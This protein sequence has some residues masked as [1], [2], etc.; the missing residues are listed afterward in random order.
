M[1]T[2][3]AWSHTV[4]H[5]QEHHEN[6]LMA[7][8][9]PDLAEEIGDAARAI[10]RKGRGLAA[11]RTS[12]AGGTVTADEGTRRTTARLEESTSDWFGNAED[13]LARLGGR[14]APKPSPPK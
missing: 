8:R 3:W 9:W 7:E 4:E 6:H 13:L 14:E 12:Y 11:I 1:T 2:G 5:V 10:V